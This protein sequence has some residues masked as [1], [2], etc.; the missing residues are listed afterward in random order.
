[1][2]NLQYAL[3]KAIETVAK[4]LLSKTLLTQPQS[5]F[6]ALIATSMELPSRDSLLTLLI[7]FSL[8][9]LSTQSSGASA[10]GSMNLIE[11]SALKILVL[12]TIM[13]PY[14]PRDQRQMCLKYFNIDL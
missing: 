9:T 4:S 8:V 7:E 3:I 10:K 12:L 14:V 11:R 13:K 1:M 2:G 6:A 5:E